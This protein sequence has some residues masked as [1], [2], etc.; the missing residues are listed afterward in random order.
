MNLFI[1]TVF[2]SLITTNIAYAYIDPGTG[3]YLIQTLMA[4]GVTVFFYLRHP[5]EFFKQ[6]IRKLFKK[7][8]N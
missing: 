2:L 5:I 4:L 6:L 7:D 3:S 1:R 8:N